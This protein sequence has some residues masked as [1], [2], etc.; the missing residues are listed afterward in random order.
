M[1]RR[2]VPFYRIGVKTIR[3]RVSDLDAA[4]EKFRVAA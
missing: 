4:M 2:L 3:F 1:A